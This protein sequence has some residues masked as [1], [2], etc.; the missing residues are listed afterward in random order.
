MVRHKNQQAKFA[1]VCLDNQLDDRD[2]TH[3]LDDDDVSVPKEGLHVNTQGAGERDTG[4]K[5]KSSPS[6]LQAVEEPKEQTSQAEATNNTKHQQKILDIAVV[7]CV[8]VSLDLVPGNLVVAIGDDNTTEQKSKHEST[9]VGIVIDV[10]E[11]A[12]Q[13]QDSQNG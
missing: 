8:W 4:D 12:D 1:K 10:G 2:Q 3:K 7:V 9:N 13:Q 6:V 5:R 11:K